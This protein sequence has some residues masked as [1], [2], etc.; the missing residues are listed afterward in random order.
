M[1]RLWKTEGNNEGRTFAKI[2][3][4]TSIWSSV[5]LDLQFLHA[6]DTCHNVWQKQSTYYEY[7]QHRTA[8]SWKITQPPFVIRNQLLPVASG[9]VKLDF[10]MGREVPN[11]HNLQVRNPAMWSPPIAKLV[12]N[13]TDSGLWD[14]KLEIFVNG[15]YE[16]LWTNIRLHG[17]CRNL[18]AATVSSDIQLAAYPR[19]TASQGFS[20]TSGKYT[21]LRPSKV[22]NCINVSIHRPS[23]RKCSE[24]ICCVVSPQCKEVIEVEWKRPEFIL[25]RSYTICMAW[26]AL[27]PTCKHSQVSDIL[28]TT[29]TYIKSNNGWGLQARHREPNHH[30]LRWIRLR[31]RKKWRALSTIA[32]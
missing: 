23:P 24:T 19:C 17:H 9:M 4:R 18:C 7:V 25:L 10:C 28:S 16:C 14:L 5:L 6:A 20:K 1:T 26:N 15:V 3:P 32:L 8:I 22:T 30:L 13:S 12:Y 27:K 2:K 21:S 11:Y 31:H 29:F